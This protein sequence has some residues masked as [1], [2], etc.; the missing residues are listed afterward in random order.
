MRQLLRGN[1][2]EIQTKSGKY[3]NLFVMFSNEGPEPFVKAMSTQ[4][5]VI[6]ALH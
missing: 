5:P 6:L 2:W 1:A 3:G 4:K